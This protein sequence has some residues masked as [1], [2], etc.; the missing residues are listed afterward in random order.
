M[1]SDN[2]VKTTVYLADLADFGKMN[3]V[4]AR[5]FAKDAPART[6]IEASGLPKGARIEIDVI[7]GF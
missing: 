5:H 4:Y 2:V 1:G 7:A 3:E 6:T